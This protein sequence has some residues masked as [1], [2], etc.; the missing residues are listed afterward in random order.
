MGQFKYFTLSGVKIKIIC[1]GKNEIA[2]ASD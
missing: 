1:S 2:D